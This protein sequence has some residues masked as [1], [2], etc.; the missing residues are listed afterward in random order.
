MSFS[1]R[2]S[3][4][5]TALLLLAI[6]IG[7]LLLLHFY[8]PTPSGL[9]TKALLE[10]LHVPIF[11]IVALSIFITT[12]LRGDWNPVQRVAAVCAATVVLSAL[13]EGAQISGPRDA[14]FDDLVS[15]WLGAGTALLFALAFSRHHPL[16][17]AARLGFTLAGLASLLIALWPFISV[18]A[19]YIERNLQQPVLVSFDAHL[20]GTFRR[21]QHTTLQLSHDPVTG[22]RLGII[23]LEEGA[24]PGLLFNDIWPDWR[25]YSALVIE[26]SLEGSA[27]LEI[28][29]RVHD[30]AHKL[31]EQ[32]Y[33][34]RFNLSYELQPGRHTLRI[35]LEQIRNAPKGRQMDLS[36][37]EGIVIFC[38]ANNAG[39]QFQLVEIR[40]E[41]VGAGRI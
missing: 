24:W 18:S 41:L 3:S 35:P 30:R 32:P 8:V 4:P 19:A 13:S 40:L 36:D 2:Q 12:G 23:T 20:G 33:K 15:D 31:G 34:D 14:S 5:A 10:S 21:A 22:K 16:R 17:P 7:L 11:G 9:W 37:I 29:V 39:R 38:S 6:S 25:E 27:P 1:T 26:L 28:N